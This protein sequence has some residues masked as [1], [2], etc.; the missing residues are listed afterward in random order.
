MRGHRQNSAVPLRD[1]NGECPC[2]AYPVSNG[3]LAMK[4][5]MSMRFIKQQCKTVHPP[6]RQEN[7]LRHMHRRVAQPLKKAGRGLNASS[8]LPLSSSGWKNSEK[9]HI[10]ICRIFINSSKSGYADCAWH[11]N[12]CQ[13]Y[14]CLCRELYK[15]KY[16]GN[17]APR[18]KSL[19]CSSFCGAV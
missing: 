19:C 7:I 16:K 6:G 10:T 4:S 9:R 17:T 2:K 15:Q 11:R 13:N 1:R 18:S 3:C 12:E 5:G 8:G 14:F